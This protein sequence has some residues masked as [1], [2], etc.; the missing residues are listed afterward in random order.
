MAS[1]NQTI[2]LMAPVSGYLMS[3]ENVPDPVFAQKMV[4]DGV[5]IDPTSQ[6]L[7]A[8]CD[9]TVM[10][11]HSAGHAVT[12]ATR[13]GVEIMM[14]I[15]LDTVQLKGKGF[16][17]QVE[18]GAE[19][20][21]GTPLITFDADFIATHA[22]SLLTQIVVTNMDRVKGLVRYEGPVTA[23]SDPVLELTL[24]EAQETAPAASG[25]SV[26]SA[27]IYVPNP[28]G[29][30]A[31]PAAVLANLAKRF[32]SDILVQRSTERANA[33][34]LTAIMRLEVGHKDQV[35]FHATGVDAQQ[36]IDAL[37]EALESG[38]HDDEPAPLAGGANVAPAG[39]PVSAPVAQSGD[40]KL[41]V[42]VAASPGLAVGKVY[43]LKRKV[44]AFAVLASD[45][46]AEHV[47]LD[48]CIAEAKGQLEALQSR[49]R[50]EAN[51]QKAAIFAA[52]A[53]MLSDPDLMDIAN[54]E[55]AKGKSAAAAWE[56]AYQAH[57][58]ILAGLKNPLFAAR[59]NDVADV[60]ARVLLM[61]VGHVTE[62]LV[63]PEQTVLVAEEL[64]PSDVAD[65]DRSRVVGFCTTSGGATS[66][67]AILARSRDIPAVAGVD[68]R[69][70][71]LADGVIVILDGG[72]GTVLPTPSAEAV[73][74]V[75]R[76]QQDHDRK[77]RADAAA[78]AQAAVTVDGH[79]LEIFANIAGVN[80]AIAAV[81]AGAEGVGVLRSEFLFMGR[82]AAPT[83]DEQTELYS[84]IATALGPERHLIIRTLD[85]GGDK[86]LTYLPI[87]KEDNPFLGERGLR[88]SLGRPEIFR[89]QLRAI[90]R[91]SKAG[92]VQIM[93]PMVT[94]LPE[95]RAAKAMVDEERAALGVAPIPVGIMI[96]VPAAAL[97]AEQFAREVDFFSVGTNDLTQ[98]T[99]AMDRSHPRL[100]AQCD[101][102]NPG[103]L[104]LIQHLVEAAHEHHRSVGVCGG[105][106]SDPQAV[107]LL[108]GL[109]VDELSVTV[110]VVS[111]IKAQVRTL[112][113]RDCQSLALAA[114]KQD[115]SAAVRAL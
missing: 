26:T 93:F 14:H 15:G 32:K 48:R 29:L 103:V 115:T 55:I 88:I 107:P 54:T 86:P 79:R 80:D 64:T 23:G 97:M 39:P 59:A 8:P 114:L 63:L 100:A 41:L 68:P 28:T 71:M 110:P 74:Q 37:T 108:M 5:S 81:K 27:A 45:A 46:K 38:L 72:K 90:L 1:T 58:K 78:S 25:Q 89:T 91:A 61:L 87:P 33:K 70:L 10:H 50:I 21:L 102:L 24:V 99:L 101:A 62:P 4:G 85:V 40:T 106:A 83:E 67:V 17:P 19:V 22:K 82:T 31:R 34:S 73:A 75:A 13:G 20:S 30:H 9:G 60:G 43:H 2:V 95:W 7:I 105:V 112:R 36:A 6:S 96:E 16:T 47:H 69:V 104:F 66:H 12:L 18:V 76:E 56:T 98:Y 53:E 42:G 57:A 52:H 84:Q 94:T 3:I 35:R 49:L 65:I 109:G 92:K 44:L 51:P 11:V 77:R 113:H 111:A